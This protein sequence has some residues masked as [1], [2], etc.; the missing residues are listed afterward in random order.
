MTL[1]EILV[2]IGGIGGALGFKQLYPI[3]SNFIKS[4]SEEN[5]LKIKLKGS[6]N[7]EIVELLKAEIQDLKE[8]N[9]QQLDK[10]IELEIGLATLRE[11]YAEKTVLKSGRFGGKRNKE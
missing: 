1:N 2:G 8:Q 11:R 6:S 10:I 9:K 5:K 7:T 3:V 4:R